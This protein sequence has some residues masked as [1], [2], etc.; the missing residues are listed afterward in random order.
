LQL[1]SRAFD[2]AQPLQIARLYVQSSHQK[3]MR[4]TAIQVE[5]KT[6]TGRAGR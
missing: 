2:E 4:P 1:I 5:A 3:V 6:L